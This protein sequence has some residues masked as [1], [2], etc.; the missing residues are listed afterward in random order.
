MS[1]QPKRKNSIFIFNEWTKHGRLASDIWLTVIIV[2]KYITIRTSI[3][4][5]PTLGRW[6]SAKRVGS[7]LHYNPPVGSEA[8]PQSETILLHYWPQNHFSDAKNGT[9]L[10][11]SKSFSSTLNSLLS[12]MYSLPGSQPAQGSGGPRPGGRPR[13][14]P[15]PARS[16]FYY[17][18]MLPTY[19]CSHSHDQKPIPT[20]I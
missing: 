2:D 14:C 12:I 13:V 8:E 20:D 19:S 10:N 7:G 11:N 18:H 5:Y 9:A 15:S 3:G 6:R 16:Q 1:Y 17:Q 4:Q